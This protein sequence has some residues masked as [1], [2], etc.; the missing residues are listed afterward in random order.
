MDEI[1]YVGWITGILEAPDN[2]SM[3]QPTRRD[4]S[5]S[6]PSAWFLSSIPSKSSS[7]PSK[8]SSIPSKSSSMPSSIPMVSPSFSPTTC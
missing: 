7:I 2:C 8:S 5:L 6:H 3:R 4:P 1:S